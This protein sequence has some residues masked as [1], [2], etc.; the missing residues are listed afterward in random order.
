[1][2]IVIVVLL[3]GDLVTVIKLTTECLSV[4]KLVILIHAYYVHL[5]QRKC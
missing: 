2:I 1:M 3:S 5:L 4:F